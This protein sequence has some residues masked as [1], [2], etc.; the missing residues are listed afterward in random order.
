VIVCGRQIDAPVLEWIRIAA[1]DLSPQ[2]LATQLCERLGWKGPGGQFQVSVA[3]GVLRRL[4]ELK[5]IS[6]S[7]AQAPLQLI[8]RVR[9]PISPEAADPVPSRAPSLEEVGPVELVGGGQPV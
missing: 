4:Q 8:R 1:A 7:K 5:A 2:K 9:P 6:L 3:V